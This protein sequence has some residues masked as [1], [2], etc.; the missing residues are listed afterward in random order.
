[1]TDEE[2]S[3]YTPTIVFPDEHNRLP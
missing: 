2:A 1:M 3:A